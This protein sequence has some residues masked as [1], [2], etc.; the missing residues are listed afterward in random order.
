MRRANP[1]FSPEP[2]SGDPA[3]GDVENVAA[4]TSRFMVERH[5]GQLP[6]RIGIATLQTKV[7]VSAAIIVQAVLTLALAG[8]A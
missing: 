2:V 7:I 3:V 4:A 8:L 1:Y 6:S 5:A